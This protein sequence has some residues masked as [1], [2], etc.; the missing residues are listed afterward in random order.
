MSFVFDGNSTVYDSSGELAARLKSFE[1]DFVVMDIDLDAVFR[2]RLKDIRRKQER[3]TGPVSPFNLKF[4]E[5]VQSKI[6]EAPPDNY[7]SM[8]RPLGYQPE[9]TVLKSEIQSV[10]EALVLGTKDYVDKNGF[11][12]VVVAISGGIDSALVSTI[13]VDALGNERVKGIYLPSQFS[14]G[15][16][17]ID[18]KELAGN[19]GIELIEIPISG[20]FEKLR[21]ELAPVFKDLPFGIAEENLQSRIR[22]NIVMALSNKFGWLVLTTGNKS[23]MSTGYATLYGDMAG[24][25]AVIK[26]V[27][28][29]TV[30]DLAGYR[31]SIKKVIPDRIIT[32]PPSAELRPDQK[33]SDS[34]PEYSVLDIIIHGY[35]EEDKTVLEIIEEI[36]DSALV[37]KVIRMIDLSEYKRR[38]AP[39][40]IKITPRAFGRDRRMPITNGY[41]TFEAR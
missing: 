41:K 40:G 10:Y 37:K 30:Y 35:V 39:P 22:G 19:L 27:L 38:Q 8:C 11:R 14:A 7:R 4:I 29:T 13:A 23:E 34:L 15:I 21:D 17:G 2:K 6:M 1:E 24:G 36:G 9:K 28:K 3:K 31:N 33:D 32:R 12:N 26:D 16:S 5:I 25:F 18:A 20:I